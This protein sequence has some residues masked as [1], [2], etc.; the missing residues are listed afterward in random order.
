MNTEPI[1]RMELLAAAFEEHRVRLCAVA[2]ARMPSILAG[3]CSPEDLIQETFVRAARQ[4]AYFHNAPGVPMFLKLR[5]LLMETIIDWERRY[6][7]AGKRNVRCEIVPDEASRDRNLW[8]HLADTISSPRS[9]L[10]R[11]ERNEQLRALLD[12]L[13]ENDREILRLRHFEHLTN[14]EC[15]VLLG[16]DGKAASIRYVRALRRFRTELIDRT[17]FAR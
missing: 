4:P 6:L 16:I 13:P 11:L 17:E 7:A 14:S 1:D 15:A 2:R 10:I 5:R 12:D 8:E 9:H 3:K